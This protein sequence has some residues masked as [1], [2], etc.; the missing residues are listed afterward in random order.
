MSIAWYYQDKTVVVRDLPAVCRV[1]DQEH[2]VFVNRDGR[3]RCLFCDDERE[4]VHAGIAR[5]QAG[6]DTL[7]RVI[8]DVCERPPEA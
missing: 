4:Q 1:C 3:S 2:Y 6:I 7:D 5:L 8:A